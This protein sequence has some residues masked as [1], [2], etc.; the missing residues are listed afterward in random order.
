M[1]D[2]HDYFFLAIFNEL[3]LPS[4]I[5]V[6]IDKEQNLGI[7]GLSSIRKG[8]CT[9]ATLFLVFYSFSIKQIQTLNTSNN[10]H[11]FKSIFDLYI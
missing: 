7:Q 4:N 10:H 3:Q 8:E 2:F 11:F 1:C 6:T 5:I 9:K